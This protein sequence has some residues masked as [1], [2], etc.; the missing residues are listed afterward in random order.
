MTIRKFNLTSMS[1]VQCTYI[2]YIM[3]IVLMLYCNNNLHK[4]IHTNK[5]AIVIQQEHIWPLVIAKLVVRVLNNNNNTKSSHIFVP[6]LCYTILMCYICSFEAHK[7]ALLIAF[8]LIL[9]TFCKLIGR[10]SNNISPGK[11]K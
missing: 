5:E 10:K 8:A 2:I 11:Y 1:I 3:Y 6:L 7:L 4:W 9:S